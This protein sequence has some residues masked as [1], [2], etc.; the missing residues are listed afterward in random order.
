VNFQFDQASFHFK[1]LPFSIPYPVPFR[2]LGDERKVGAG[3]GA[4]APSLA[5]LAQPLQLPSGLPARLLLLPRA[6]WGGARVYMFGERGGGEERANHLPPLP[7]ACA[8]GST[9]V[10]PSATTQGWIDVTY[11]SSEGDFRLSRGNKA[12][13]WHFQ[14][15]ALLSPPLPWFVLPS[16]R[17]T[18][19]RPS[20]ALSRSGHAVCAG[21]G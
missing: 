14:A 5:G 2:L 4:R 11:M 12:S 13:C 19:H 10:R 1:F 18:S 15:A 21:Q 20:P 7:R 3:A 8:C 17:A 9:P 16:P 6:F